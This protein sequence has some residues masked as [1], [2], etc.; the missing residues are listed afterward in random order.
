MT[1][2]LRAFLGVGLAGFIVQLA[3]LMVLVSWWH[4]PYVWA[5]ILAVEA[6][7][8]HNYAWHRRWTWADRSPSGNGAHG[9]LV[10][11][12]LGTGL[13]SIAGNVI[14]TVI[15]V[16][17]LHAPAPL[18][19][20]GAVAATTAANFL[21][22]DRWV[23]RQAV[24]VATALSLLWPSPV[25]A[26]DLAQ[27][28]TSAWAQH[29]AHVESVWHAHPDEPARPE[30]EGHTL[31]VP[32]GTVHE[33][34]GSVI[35]RGITVAALVQALQ[36]RGLPPPADDILAARVLARSGDS[37]RVY[38][39]VTRSA[40]ITV[41]YDTEHDV[42]FSRRSPDFAT[43][44]SVA[45]RIQEVGGSDR[46]FLWRLNSY[47]RYRQS[48]PD[49]VV[50]LLSETL[51]RD[52]PVLARPIAGPIIDRIARDSVQRTLSAVERFGT[53]VRDC[54]GAGRVTAR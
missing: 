7:V 10:R 16:E 44:R 34:R 20:V 6:A 46:G 4:V 27:A 32:G 25:R 18:A 38:M 39:K 54:D 30:I 31:S 24:V 51:S 17:W 12:H 5:T 21:I 40:I 28:T 49:V 50:D 41:T 2:R 19:N 42:T 11:F 9:R 36:T 3:V 13:T 35:I 45:T 8:L 29:I 52:V 23:F 33:W 37:L 43:S 22:A 26:A 53:A 48:G 47:W 1:A 14:G 15:G